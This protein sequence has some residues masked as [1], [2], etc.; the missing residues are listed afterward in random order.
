[1]ETIPGFDA[2]AEMKWYPDKQAQYQGVIGR[3]QAALKARLT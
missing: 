2:I 1:M 3:A